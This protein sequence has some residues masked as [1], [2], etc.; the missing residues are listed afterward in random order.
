M[1][2]R[3]GQLLWHKGF[4]KWCIVLRGGKDISIVNFNNKKSTPV[5]VQNKH[6]SK[7]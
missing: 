4:N 7:G 2:T 6:F 1:V 3:K 5:E